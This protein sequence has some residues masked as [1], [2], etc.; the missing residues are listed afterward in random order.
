MYV[1]VCERCYSVGFGSISAAIRHSYSNHFSSEILILIRLARQANKKQGLYS[2]SWLGFNWK[3]GSRTTFKEKV[4]IHSFRIHFRCLYMEAAI[5]FCGIE[6]ML[7]RIS[8]IRLSRTL[9]FRLTFRN[10]VILGG[11]C[12]IRLPKKI[13][14]SPLNCTR[15]SSQKGKKM[16]R[17]LI[18]DIWVLTLFAILDPCQIHFRRG[19]QRMIPHVLVAFTMLKHSRTTNHNSYATIG[20]TGIKLDR[21]IK[22]ISSPV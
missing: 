8:R 12:Y 1:G 2:A 18:Y 11:K 16:V 6:L 9:A 5:Q 3:F 17:T 10:D 14:T 20:R 15:F 21:G 19:V 4:S 22:K 13:S 7:R